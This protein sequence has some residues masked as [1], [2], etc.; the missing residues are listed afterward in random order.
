MEIEEIRAEDSAEDIVSVKTREKVRAVK[1]SPCGKA[2]DFW[3]D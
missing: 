1:T 3:Q 2:A